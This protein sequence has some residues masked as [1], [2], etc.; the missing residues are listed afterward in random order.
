MKADIK[1]RKFY[2]RILAI[3]LLLALWQTAAVLMGSSILLP[4]P[5]AV[6]KRLFTIW[7]E[8][9]FTGA[10]AFSFV[11]IAGGFLL[12]FTTGIL[13][14]VLAGKSEIAEI[15]LSPV[16]VTV[17]SVPVASIIIIALVWLSSSKLSIFISFLMVLPVIYSN[18]LQGIKS[19]DPKLNEMADVFRLDFKKRFRFIWIPSIKPFLLSS[20]QVALGL[21]WKSG[22]AAEVIGIPSGS[23]GEQLYQAKA[24]LNTVDLFAWTVIIVLISVCFEKLCMTILKSKI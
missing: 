11:R 6:I 7:Q 9:G 15:F 3:L 2:K 22:V 10:I 23:I 19:I 20:T 5:L 1:D 17:K 4:S 8:D 12:A 18:V 21:A 14:A 16:M 24:Y 13:L